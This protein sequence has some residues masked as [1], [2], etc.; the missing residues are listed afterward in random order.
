[1]LEE[2]G[3][4]L[5]QAYTERSFSKRRIQV[6]ENVFYFQGYG[7]SNA[8]LIIGKTSCILVDC[9]DSDIRGARLKTEIETLTEKPVKTLI[10]THGHPD[11]QGGAGAFSDTLEEIIAH[12][13]LRPVLKQTKMVMGELMHRGAL[14]FGAMLSEEELITQGLGPREGYQSNDGVYHPLPATTIYQG[15]SIL[16]RTL[17]GVQIQFIPAV[18]ETDDQMYIWLPEHN[19]FCCGDNFYPCF[20]NLYAL[21]GSQYRDVAEWVDSLGLILNYPVEYLLPGHGYILEGHDTVVDIISIYRDAIQSVL[22][23]TLEGMAKGKSIDALA[24]EI[25]L[26]EAIREHTVLGE[27]YGSVEWSVRSIYNGYAGWFDGNPT[28]IH[29]MSP[30][31]KAEEMVALAGGILKIEEAI[32]NAMRDKKYIWAME[33]CDALLNLNEKEEQTKKWK[34]E[35]CLALAD[36]ETS[37]NGRH[38]YLS[39]AKLLMQ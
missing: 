30:K 9:L 11:H 5:L 10:Y 17:D 25:Q 1:M 32:H 22:L 23:Q 15:E 26:P 2:N 24:T 31:E 12:A 33:L 8:T 6:A 3:A 29:G 38:Y 37:S 18:G 20:P 4:K 34:A 16:N 35:C 36:Q 21:R 39:S 19:I 27:H 14:Q 7:H 13:P 28:H